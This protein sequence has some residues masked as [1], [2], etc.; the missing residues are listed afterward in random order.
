MGASL[1]LEGGIF[2]RLKVIEKH[3]HKDSH[4]T[5]KCICECGKEVVVQ[6]RNLKSGRTKSCSCLQKEKASL[7]RGENSHSWRGGIKKCSSGYVLIYCPNHPRAQI[8]GGK[9][10]RAGGYV[11]EHILV[12]EKILGRYLLKGENVHHKNG[13]RDDN[14]EDNLELWV[15]MQPSG[16]RPS[17]LV[18]YAR[19]ILLRYA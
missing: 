8:P 18:Q 2:G 13:V 4:I 17:D 16:Q 3:G 5:W 14:R 11:L 10:K 6:G 1:N 19:E 15:T 12:M 7:R 9:N